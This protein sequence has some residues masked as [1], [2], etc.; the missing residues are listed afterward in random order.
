MPPHPN[1]KHGSRPAGDRQLQRRRRRIFYRLQSCPRVFVPTRE[2]FMFLNAAIRDF[3]TDLEFQGRA[4]LTRKRH[5]TELKL[6]ARWIESEQLEWSTLTRKELQRYLRSRAGL[7]ASARGNMLC[8]FRTFFNWALDQELIARS[9]AVGFRTPRRP[10]PLPRALTTSQ[11]Q[12]LIRFLRGSEGR[13]AHRDA[14]LVITGLYAGLRACE[15]AE[16]D[17]QHIDFDA[18]VIHIE[19]S[20]MNKGRAVP[21]HAVLVAEL[22]QWRDEQAGAEDWPCFSLD[23]KPLAAARAG[24]IARKISAQSKVKFTTHVLRHTFATWTLRLS[25]DIYS[26]SKS[27][28]HAALRQTEVYVSAD[29]EQLR[30]AVDKLPD[31]ASW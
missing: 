2:V 25:H 14:V 31:L 22:R 28:G 16:L 23:G 6:L 21:L 15:L 8:S 27:L 9:P 29:V 5:R 12:K 19:L 3:C 18:G 26:V 1:A 13:T 7:S 10:L 4:P 24:K 20:K 11:M 17:W 30:Q